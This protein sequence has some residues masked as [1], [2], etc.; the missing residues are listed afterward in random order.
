LTCDDIPTQQ[1]KQEVDDI[2]QLLTHHMS[3]VDI[4][5]DVEY[6]KTTWSE[7]EEWK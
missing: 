4:L 2:Q 7:K 6:T 1:L 5:V 3:A